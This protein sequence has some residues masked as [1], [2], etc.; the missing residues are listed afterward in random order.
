MGKKEG[1]K[2]VN[3]QIWRV[4]SRFLVLGAKESRNLPDRRSLA[5]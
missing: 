4:D 5:G 3:V 1:N 2:Y